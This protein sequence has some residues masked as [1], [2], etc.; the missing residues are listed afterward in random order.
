MSGYVARFGGIERLFGR[1]GSRRLRH[2][3]I[4]V[5]GIGGVGSWAVEALARSGVG[6]LTLVDLDEVCISNTNR[7][8]HAVQGDYGLPKVEVM[9]R[10]VLSINPE[11]MVHPVQSF[12]TPGTADALLSTPYDCLLDAIDRPAQKCLLLARARQLGRFI[13]ATGGAG[14]RRDPCRIRTDDLA[15]SSHD[16]L[17]QEVRRSLRRD[18]GFPRGLTPFGVTAVFST[19]PQV[20]PTTEGGVCDRRAPEQD[21]R[22]DCE[23][24]FGTAAFVTGAFGLTAAAAAVRGIVLGQEIAPPDACRVLTLGD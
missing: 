7:Q 10:R 2:A 15:F 20:F 9:A 12:F 3:H 11:C 22:L 17:L 4:C 1:E 24:G 21:L 19:E 23:S 16:I 6:R 13:V 14:G 5:V 18:Y 8:L